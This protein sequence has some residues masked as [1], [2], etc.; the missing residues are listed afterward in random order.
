VV[1]ISRNSD[2][3]VMVAR[4]IPLK[5]NKIIL[6]VSRLTMNSFDM[7]IKKIIDMVLMAD[8]NGK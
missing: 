3:D 1:D 5:R 2:H 7:K 8:G 6:Y 4:G